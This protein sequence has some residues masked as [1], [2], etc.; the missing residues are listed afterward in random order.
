M[1]R[2]LTVKGARWLLRAAFLVATA[3]LP[4]GQAAAQGQDPA[5]AWPTRPIRLIVPYPPGSGIDIVARLLG[6]RIGDSLGQPI[7]VD[8]RPGAG[9]IIGV[10]AVAKSA[11]DGYTIGFAD[12]GPLAINPSLYPKLPYDPVKDLAPIVEVGTL[13]FM[14]VVHP[15]L[16][17]SSVQELIDAAKRQPGRLNY[18]SVGNGTSVHLATEL[19]TRQA[20]IQMTHIPYKGSV[21]ALADVLSGTTPVMF[22]NLLS[23]LSFVKSGQLRVLGV[24]TSSRIKALPDVPTVAESGV[25][26]YQFVAW[27]GMFAPAGTPSFIVE[28]LNTEIDRALAVPDFRDQLLNDG[29]LQVVGGT[30]AQFSSLIRNE[31]V[32]WRKLVKETGVHLD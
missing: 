8:N 28:R 11:P 5:Q 6:Q 22:V 13:P 15:S 21:P 12:T 18:A 32:Y 9:A 16:G 4:W 10:D 23:G 26:G 19:F 24:S 1:L 27:I 20:G 7:I 14:L 31:V 29:G 25:P 17:V 2:A 3:A 30:S